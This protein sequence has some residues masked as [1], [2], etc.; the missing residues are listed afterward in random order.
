MAGLASHAADVTTAAPIDASVGRRSC[1]NLQR[2]AP[3]GATCGMRRHPERAL[4]ELSVGTLAA[5]EA[6]RVSW[7]SLAESQTS[8]AILRRFARDQ[9]V[10]INGTPRVTVLVGGARARS[11]WHDWLKAGALEGTLLDDRLDV[12]MRVA[13]TR[14][15]AE[16]AT[17][18]AVN[19]SPAD[20]QSWRSGR[21][22]RLAVMVDEGVLEIPDEVAIA[23]SGRKRAPTG[24]L[25]LARP[26]AFNARSAAEAALLEALE[27]TPATAGRF[28]PNG[29]LSVRFGPSAL[30][31]DLLARED[32]IAIDI[33]GYYHFGDL[34]AYRRDRR[35]DLVLQTQGFV[36]VRVLAHDVMKDARPAVNAIC[37]ALACR[38]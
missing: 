31:V 16:P 27:A 23:S 30:E 4:R 10:R 3:R 25:R 21:S 5:I 12:A 1:V 8:D 38:R 13:A 34:D 19:C 17:P 11:L 18:I 37:Q 22:D 33:D 24:K 35:K 36:V 2:S 28:E 26:H 20:L 29:F 6:S 9:W 7:G 15:I 32:R 14:A